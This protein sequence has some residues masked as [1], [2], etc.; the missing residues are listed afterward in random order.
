MAEH[1]GV[2]CCTPK[3]DPVDLQ[4]V[5]EGPHH[6]EGRERN[7]DASNEQGFERGKDNGERTVLTGSTIPAVARILFSRSAPEI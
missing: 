4:A 1:S 5:L 2:I 6:A 7:A 3:Y